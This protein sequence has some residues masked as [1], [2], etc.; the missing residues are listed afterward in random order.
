M[1]P[2][3]TAVYNPEKKKKIRWGEEMGKQQNQLNPLPPAVS[4]FLSN[5]KKSGR[6]TTI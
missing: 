3:Q 5:K 4:E 1:V 2:I 6:R